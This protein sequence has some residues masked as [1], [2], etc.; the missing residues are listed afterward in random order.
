[1]INKFMKSFMDFLEARVPLNKARVIRKNWGKTYRPGSFG[2]EIEFRVYNSTEREFD[3]EYA[4]ETFK[5]EVDTPEDVEAWLEDNKEPK[6]PDRRDYEYDSDPFTNYWNLHGERVEVDKPLPLPLKK[7]SKSKIKELFTGLPERF[8]EYLESELSQVVNRIKS[9]YS[10]YGDSYRRYNFEMFKSSRNMS[11]YLLK[12]EA[13]TNV[14][15]ERFERDLHLRFSHDFLNKKQAAYLRELQGSVSEAIKYFYEFHKKRAESTTEEKYNKEIEK[16]WES[17]YKKWEEQHE[18]WE[19]ERRKVEDEWDEWDEDREFERWLDKQPS[20]A[21][22]QQRYETNRN[23]FYREYEVDGDVSEDIEDVND[24]IDEN[25]GRNWDVNEDERGVVE[26]VSPI[27]T[28][29]D[30]GF[31]KKILL[32]L[33]NKNFDDQTGLHVHVGMPELTD[34]FDLLAFV[35]TV[36]EEAILAMAYRTNDALAMYTRKKDLLFKSL[37]NL[38]EGVMDNSSFME[39]FS[40]HVDR[41][42]GVNAIKAFEKYKTVELR[43]LSSLILEKENGIEKLLNYINYFLM[44]P[45]IAFGRSQIRY[46]VPDLGTI[47]FTR[48]PGGKI[49]VRKFTSKKPSVPMSGLPVSD[50]R[51]KDAS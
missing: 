8:V 23:R 17:D 27:L 45:K 40:R 29:G 10:G 5:R 28:T 25:G 51:K 42:Y 35:A 9:I 14:T 26:V 20:S 46:D 1:M 22:H 30:L 16:I 38:P 34:A 31:V 18:E 13:Q 3:E 11:D 2:I 49:D 44:I 43:Y 32:Y 24:W 6:E 37:W 48:R 39:K 36:D 33:S 4:L 47:V 21:Y 12:L 15:T 50:L 41:Y 7:L 19:E